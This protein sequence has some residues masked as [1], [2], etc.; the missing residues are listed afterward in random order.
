M[1]TLKNELFFFGIVI[2]IDTCRIK[3]LNSG[4]EVILSQDVQNVVFLVYEAK[5]GFA[6]FFGFRW[7]INILKLNEY[8]GIDVQIDVLL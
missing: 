5:L 1:Q 8:S 2:K 6:S 7:H 4:M 3:A